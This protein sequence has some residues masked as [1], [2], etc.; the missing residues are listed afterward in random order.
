[1]DKFIG[2]DIDHK[3]TLACVVQTGQPTARGSCG[4]TWINFGSGLRCSA[5]LATGFT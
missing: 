5:G 1:M 3:R 2:F 4:P